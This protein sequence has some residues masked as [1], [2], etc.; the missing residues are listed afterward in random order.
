QY[1]SA[2]GWSCA[3]VSLDVQSPQHEPHQGRALRLRVLGSRTEEK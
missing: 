2:V 3:R 1:L